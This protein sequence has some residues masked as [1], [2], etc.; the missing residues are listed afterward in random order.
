MPASF[1]APC[2]GE[3]MP[4]CFSAARCCRW[5][6]THHRACMIGYPRTRRCGGR[7]WHCVGQHVLQP[8]ALRG[9]CSQVW[10]VRGSCVAFDPCATPTRCT[11]SGPGKPIANTETGV[12]RDVFWIQHVFCTKYPGG[13][14]AKHISNYDFW[15]QNTSQITFV[16]AVFIRR[17]GCKNMSQITIAGAV[18]TQGGGI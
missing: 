7:L 5:R 11:R 16:G 1:E 12:K 2:D 9:G 18:F 13:L 3:M 17:A 15:M 6:T 4:C 14:G 10:A 8:L